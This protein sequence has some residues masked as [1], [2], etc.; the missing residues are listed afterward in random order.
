MKLDVLA[1]GAHPDDVELGCA[2]TLLKERS[3]GKE[4]GV[5]DLTRGELGTR[6]TP[7]IRKKEADNAAAH[8][9]LATRVNLGLRDALFLNDNEN[10]LKIVEKIRQ[11]R[12]EIVICTAVDDRHIDHPRGSKLVSEACFLSGLE[13]IETTHA[14]VNQEKWR[15]RQVLHY[16]QWRDLK[17]DVVVDISDF[18]E[19]KLEVVKSYASQF[20]NEKSKEPRTPIS[21]PNFLE[22]V[23]YRARN[24]GRLSGI[25]YAEGFVTERCP[26]VDSV[27]DLI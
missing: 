6:G 11:Y 25:D 3:R 12:P 10:K 17:P 23:T 18:M 13:K 22:S 5:L 15:P 16:I 4:I 9:K 19:G 24:L 1:V 8:L 2:G 21:S 26:T 7:E 27:F 20:H 14:G